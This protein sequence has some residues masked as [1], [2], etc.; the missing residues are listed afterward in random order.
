MWRSASHCA[1]ARSRRRRRRAHPRVD[2]VVDREVRR[3]AHEVVAAGGG[4]PP[5]ARTGGTGHWSWDAPRG[6]E[7]AAAASGPGYST[8]STGR[9][10]TIPDVA[11]GV[12]RCADCRRGT[13]RCVEARLP[14]RLPSGR[15]GSGV[16]GRRSSG[17]ARAPTS[18]GPRTALRRSAPAPA[19][20]GACR[21]RRSAAGRPPRPRSCSRRRPPGTAD[22]VADGRG[23]RAGAAV[24]LDVALD[25]P[26]Q[27]ARVEAHGEPGDRAVGPHPVD[28][29]LHRRRRET[30][31]PPM[32][33]KLRRASS[34]SM[35]TI[36][37]VHGVQ[38]HGSI[39]QHVSGRLRGRAAAPGDPAPPGA[40]L[41]LTPGNKDRLLFDDVLWVHRAQEEHDRFADVL[42]DQ[43]VTVHLFGDLLRRTLELPDA[44]R[45][46]S[47]RS[48]TS[49]STARWPSTRC[50]TASTRSTA[51]RSPSTSSAG[52]PSGRCS[53]GSPSRVPWPST[54]SGPTTSCWSRCPT[55]STPATRRPGSTAAWRSTACARWRGCGRRR[56]TRRSTAGT[57]CSPAAGSRC[58]RRARRT[59]SRRPRAATCSSSAGA[60]CWSG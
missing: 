28:A 3:R 14:C 27:R 40:E 29:A 22:G 59:G 49:G 16:T 43:G 60:R 10:T 31:R 53:T 54:C 21:R 35:P 20:S 9:C 56:T 45:T 33:A 25:R 48:S 11:G 39:S 34:T 17:L 8:V 6:V 41:R 26:A 13:D 12:V 4:P 23:R 46:S 30:H 1:T 36:S 52:S 50:A 18:C 15:R 44:S 19:R 47:T 24:Q 57:R 55:T 42:R 58:G 7:G 2:R 38:R 37:F 32:S 5:A 51:T